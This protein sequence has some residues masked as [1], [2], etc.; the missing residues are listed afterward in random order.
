M[1]AQ[2]V[3]QQTNMH[4][5]CRDTDRF[6]I[7]SDNLFEFTLSISYKHIS[8]YFSFSYFLSLCKLDGGSNDTAVLRDPLAGGASGA[9]FLI[10]IDGLPTEVDRTEVFSSTIFRAN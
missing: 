5:M 4:C 8:K 6:Q 1:H 10:D 3:M 7:F 9:G 2:V